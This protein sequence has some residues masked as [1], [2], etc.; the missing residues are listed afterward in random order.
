[1]AKS[2]WPI[3]SISLMLVLQ[4]GNCPVEEYQVIIFEKYYHRKINKAYYLEKWDNN[5]LTDF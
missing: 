4:N 5:P 1:M 3:I 2:S